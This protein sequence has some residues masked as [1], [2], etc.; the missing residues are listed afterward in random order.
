[1]IYSGIPRDNAPGAN[2]AVE[3]QVKWACT[4]IACDGT[5]TKKPS[6]DADGDNGLVVTS[7]RR[8]L[9]HRTFSAKVS[10]W[11]WKR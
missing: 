3:C 8:C 9:L 1:M 7:A 5:T 4:P 11:H 2:R 10:W 6:A